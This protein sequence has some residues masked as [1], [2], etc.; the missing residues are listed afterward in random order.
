MVV[1]RG[2]LGEGGLSGGGGGCFEGEGFGDDL[3]K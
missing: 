2:F 3:L 1:T